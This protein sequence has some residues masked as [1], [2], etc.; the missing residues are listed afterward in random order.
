MYLWQVETD[1]K[2]AFVESMNNRY[3]YLPV[4]DDANKRNFTDGG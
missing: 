1:A 2:G 4:A 3:I